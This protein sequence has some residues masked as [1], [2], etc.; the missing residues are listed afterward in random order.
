MNKVQTISELKRLVS[1]VDSDAVK[2]ILHVTI[3]AIETNR[4][5]KLAGIA[6]RWDANRTQILQT[7]EKRAMKGA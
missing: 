1:Q 7:F 2:E 5:R 3:D 4:T 6:K